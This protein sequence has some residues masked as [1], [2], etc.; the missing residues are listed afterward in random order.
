MKSEFDVCIIGSG[1]GA[2]PVA[3]ELAQSGFKV[4]VLEKGP[5]FK[6]EDFTK[7]EIACCR[8]DT[9]TPQ[10]KDE[11]HVIEDKKNDKWTATSNKDLNWSFG[12]VT[13]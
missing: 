2:G 8:R 12:M 10:L 11:S 13:W 7:D 1:A 6:E 5:W 4:L 9:Y 3:Y